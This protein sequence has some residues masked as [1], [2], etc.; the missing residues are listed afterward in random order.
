MPL[1]LVRNQVLLFSFVEFAH[2]NLIMPKV[3]FCST[4]LCGDTIYGGLFNKYDV[5]LQYFTSSL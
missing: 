5:P 3:S 1:F 4:G 2:K